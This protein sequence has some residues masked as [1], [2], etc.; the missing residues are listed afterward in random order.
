VT[1]T[2]PE[3]AY[4][5]KEEGRFLGTALELIER[6]KRASEANWPSKGEI[7]QGVA[8]LRESVGHKELPRAHRI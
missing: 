2:T 4:R 6:F 5:A 1:Q 3:L 7:A 8:E